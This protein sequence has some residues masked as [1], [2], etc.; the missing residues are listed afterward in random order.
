MTATG[1]KHA[2]RDAER[3]WAAAASGDVTFRFE[4]KSACTTAVQ[5]LHYWRRL[6][7]KD[8]FNGLESFYDPF[9]VTRQSPTEI[10]ITRRN[11]NVIAFDAN[12]NRI[13]LDEIQK[14]L[15]NAA[16]REV[17][18]NSRNAINNHRRKHGLAPL[19]DN[20]PLI[21]TDSEK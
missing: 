20:A 15:D 19:D 8:S 2:F 17:D 1:P 3:M 12:G 6:D 21:D 4:T 10:K 14:Q 11:T 9:V 16:N 7:R 5:R 18:M 13:D